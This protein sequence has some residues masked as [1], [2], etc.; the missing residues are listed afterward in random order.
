M[1]QLASSRG[2][3]TINVVRDRN[4]SDELAKVKEDLVNLGKGTGGARVVVLSESEIAGLRSFEDL[5][6]ASSLPSLAPPTLGLNCTG[7]ASSSSAMRLLS[8]GS[9]FVTYGGLSKK[10]LTIPASALIFR[11]IKFVGFWLSKGLLQKRDE[12]EEEQRRRA[13]ALR[14]RRSD[15]DRVASLVSQGVISTEVEK[16][17]MGRWQDALAALRK[18]GTRARKQV[19]VP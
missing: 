16:V 9:R 6:S 13:E 10:P 7:A 12:N 5:T 8:P 4:S 1:I 11:D 15:L 14:R 3:S 19:L 2:V 17:P 18:G